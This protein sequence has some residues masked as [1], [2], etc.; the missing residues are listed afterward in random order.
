MNKNYD[1]TWDLKRLGSLNLFNRTLSFNWSLSPQTR[2]YTLPAYY[3]D[4]DYITVEVTATR[5]TSDS[6]T[7]YDGPGYLYSLQ[8]EFKSPSI[9][10]PDS[11]QSTSLAYA[12]YSNP[13]GYNAVNPWA[14]GS[15]PLDSSLPWKDVSYSASGK[16]V[17]GSFKAIINNPFKNSTKDTYLHGSMALAAKV[18]SGQSQTWS[19]ISYNVDNN[20]LTITVE[21]PYKETL[22]LTIKMIGHGVFDI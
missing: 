11:A 19:P 10:I 6:A 22:S 2:T 13:N 15:L 21:V 9:A 7:T 16:S 4:L 14:S 1:L 18:G 12:I 8:A 3:K 17:S 20:K 5:T